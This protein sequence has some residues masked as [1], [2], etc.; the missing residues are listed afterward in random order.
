MST[1]RCSAFPREMTIVEKDNDFLG[2]QQII[3][4]ACQFMTKE[5]NSIKKMKNFVSCKFLQCKGVW[6]SLSKLV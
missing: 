5:E 4:R 6:V 2:N 3:P 1:W